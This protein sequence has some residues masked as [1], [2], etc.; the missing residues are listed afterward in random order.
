MCYTSFS[1]NSETPSMLD[2]FLFLIG[3][4][5]FFEAV[6]VVLAIIAAIVGK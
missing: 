6:A 5:F 1:I 4:Y 2:F 3:T